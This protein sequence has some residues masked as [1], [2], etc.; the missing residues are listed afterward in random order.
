MTKD[1]QPIADS[2]LGPGLRRL[3]RDRADRFSIIDEMRR[4]AFEGVS[5]EEI[6]Q[7]AARALP[8]VREEMR[9]RA[10]PMAGGSWKD[11]DLS[12]SEG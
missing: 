6:E 1:K 2:A 10:S 12:P 9:A 11:R 8:E 3:D 4:T 7:E 5:T